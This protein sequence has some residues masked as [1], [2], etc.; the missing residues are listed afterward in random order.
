MSNE[1][2]MLEIVNDLRD[3][4]NDMKERLTME[5][6]FKDEQIRYLQVEVRKLSRAYRIGVTNSPSISELVFTNTQFDSTRPCAIYPRYTS[7]IPN[8]SFYH[9]ERCHKTHPNQ[10]SC[11][12]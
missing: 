6:A 7:T 5:L 1:G 2:E 3:Q 8:I 9:C 10:F 11:Y 4:Y 12:Y